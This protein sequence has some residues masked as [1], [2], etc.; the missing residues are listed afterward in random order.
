MKKI[1]IQLLSAMTLLLGC[2]KEEISTDLLSMEI[3]SKKVEGNGKLRIGDSYGGGIVAYI[4]Q[5]GD[6][7]YRRGKQNGLIAAPVDQSSGAEWGCFGTAL[8]GV[9]GTTLGTGNQNTINIEAGCTATGTAADICANWILGGYTDWYLP[10]KDELY[11]LY[12]NQTAIGGFDSYSSYWSSSQTGPV[13]AYNTN[14]GYGA[15]DGGYSK[16]FLCRVRAVRTF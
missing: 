11:K 13:A 14:F 4:L 9:F 10:S 8:S 3:A 5:P 2:Q 15:Q 1:G 6:L 7:G 16:D 12:L